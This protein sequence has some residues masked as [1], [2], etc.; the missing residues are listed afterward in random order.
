MNLPRTEPFLDLRTVLD[1]V[2][3]LRNMTCIVDPSRAPRH[4][5]LIKAQLADAK[6]LLE[7]VTNHLDDV[8]S[9]QS[10]AASPQKGG[11]A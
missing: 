5:D 8:M 9:S 10:D 7:E 1:L 3:N 4:P 11:A 2:T 6:L